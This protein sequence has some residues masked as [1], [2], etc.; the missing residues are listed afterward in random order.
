MN[1]QIFMKKNFSMKIKIIMVQ[2]QVQNQKLITQ[3][4]NLGDKLEDYIKPKKGYKNI[5]F[6]N[7]FEQLKKVVI[8]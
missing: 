5:L 1:F 4:I 7:N 6:K 8:F 3:E 2:V